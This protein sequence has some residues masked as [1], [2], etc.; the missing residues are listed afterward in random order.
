MFFLFCYLKIAILL[1]M[2]LL[3]ISIFYQYLVDYLS[4]LIMYL[5]FPGLEPPIISILYR[6]PGIYVHFN[7]MLSFIFIQIIIKIDQLLSISLS[8]T[9]KAFAPYR[10]VAILSIFCNFLSSL[11]LSA[12]L[13][14][15]SVYTLCAS[16]LKLCWDYSISL[17]LNKK[18][19]RWLNL[20]ILFITHIFVPFAFLCRLALSIK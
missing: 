19:S 6:W 13:L 10:Y 18:S 15:Y 5:F 9:L 17:L 20:S 1:Y 3:H 2:N 12:I 11:L 14:I 16:I 4:T 7:L 8:H